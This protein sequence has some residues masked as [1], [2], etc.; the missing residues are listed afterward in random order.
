M[1]KTEKPTNTEKEQVKSSAETEERSKAEPVKKAVKSEEKPEKTAKV[2]K[3]EE[4]KADLFTTFNVGDT[5]KVNYKIVEAGK[6]RI[7]PFEGIVLAKKGEGI[8]KTF[9]VRKLGNRGVGVERIFP[10]YSPKIAS[11]DVV[12]KGKVRRAKLYYLR[13]QRS[14]KEAKI[15]ELAKPAK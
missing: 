10:V 5:V 12:R 8:S 3:K 9:I 11:I 1:A 15:K 13:Q 2:E 6:E 4:Q 14:K 7:Q